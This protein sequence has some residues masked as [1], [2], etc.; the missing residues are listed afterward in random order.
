MSAL[1][2]HKGGDMQHLLVQDDPCGKKILRP[3]SKNGWSFQDFDSK[4]KS[5]KNEDLCPH[6]GD[7]AQRGTLDLWVWFG[8]TRSETFG[9]ARITIGD[10]DVS[11]KFTPHGRLGNYRVFSN[12]QWLAIFRPDRW[13]GPNIIQNGHCTLCSQLHPRHF[14]EG[15]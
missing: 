11:R 12:E 15:K 3:G 6:L 2:L 1:H 14:V 9:L 4:W 8:A 7:I 10:D 13:C 5:V